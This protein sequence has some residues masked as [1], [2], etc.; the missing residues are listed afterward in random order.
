MSVRVIR[1]IVCPACGGDRAVVEGWT[2]A[3]MLRPCA[4]CRWWLDPVATPRRQHCSY[5]RLMTDDTFACT[6]WEPRS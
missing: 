1:D 5:L 6:A 4:T 2:N 3:P